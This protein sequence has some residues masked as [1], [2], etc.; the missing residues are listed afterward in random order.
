MTYCGLNIWIYVFL[1]SALVACEWSASRLHRCTPEDR[2][3]AIHCIGS[4]VGPRV[5][6]DDVEKRIFFT[7]Q[8]LE[9]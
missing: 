6:L 3:P 2:S 4:W 9:L 1:T 7:L 8:R 5:G